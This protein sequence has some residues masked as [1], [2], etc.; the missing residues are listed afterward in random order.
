MCIPPQLRR[1]RVVFQTRALELVHKAVCHWVR[2]RPHR[3]VSCVDGR[4]RQDGTWE[5]AVGVSARVESGHG[6]PP[7][8]GGEMLRQTPILR[9]VST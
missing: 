9:E 1:K 2:L 4:T 3:W 5:M 8:H 7:A 6:E